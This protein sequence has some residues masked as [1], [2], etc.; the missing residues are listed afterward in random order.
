[1]IHGG[2]IPP[3]SGPKGM[4]VFQSL[5]ELV[6]VAGMVAVTVNHRFHGAPMLVEV[7]GDVRD[8]IRHVRENAAGNGID[9]DRL[10]LWVFSGGGPL[11]SSALREG[12]EHVKALVA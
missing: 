12:P 7:A 3:G 9:G 4:G 8:L 6:A 5:G 10:A 1:L 11:V 2:P